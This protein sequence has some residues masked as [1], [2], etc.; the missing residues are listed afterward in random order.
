MYYLNENIH[1]NISSRDVFMNEKLNKFLSGIN[2]YFSN[3]SYYSYFRHLI[4]TVIN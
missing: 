3:V 2:K 4:F 1:P